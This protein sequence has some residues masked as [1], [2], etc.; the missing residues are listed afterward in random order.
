MRRTLTMVILTG[1]LAVL[2]STPAYAFDVVET[3]TL[4]ISDT[5]LG[6]VNAG[7]EFGH[8]IP[9]EQ[10]KP[11]KVPILPR[12]DCW[13]GGK[14]YSDGSIITQLGVE[15]VCSNGTW[16]KYVSQHDKE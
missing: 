16:K 8:E 9:A 6:S 10:R 11:R 5:P 14:A 7:P 2:G 12:A 15:H 4:S 1:V 13:Y 3:P